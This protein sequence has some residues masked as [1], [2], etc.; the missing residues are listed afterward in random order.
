MSAPAR[1]NTRWRTR[2]ESRIVWVLLATALA[3]KVSA[4]Q[5]KIGEIDASLDTTL[6]TGIS[7][8]LSDPDRKY[9]GTASGGLQNSVNADD[10]NLNYMSGINSLIAKGTSDLELGFG[11]FK[12]FARAYYFYDFENENGDRARTPL[13]AEALER[14]GSDIRLL[15]AFVVGQFEIGTSPLDLRLGSQVLSWGEST[16]IQN[17]INVINP[18]DVSSI[19]V[20][21]AELK[22]ALLPVPMI[23]ASYG[24]TENVT[25]EGFYQFQWEETIIDPPGTYFSSNDFAGR[26]GSRVYL[27]FGAIADTSPLGFVSR[28]PDVDPSDSGQFGLAARI[29]VPE[30]NS[31]EFGFYFVNYHSR[32]PTIS[33]VTPSVPIN[34]NLTGPLTFVFTQAGLPPEQASAAASQLFGILAKYTVGGPGALTPQELAV[35]Q[36]PQSQAAIENAKRVAFLQSANTGQYLIEYG[37]DIQLYGASFNTTIGS[38]GISLQGEVSYKVGVPLQVDDVE[39]LFAALSAINPAFGPNNQLGNYLGQL[40]TYIP[41]YTKENVWQV[42]TTAT[43]VFGPA[44][45]ASQWLLLGEIGVTH[46]PGLPDKATLRFD[47]SGTFTSGSQ[48]FMD[49]TGNGMFPATPA[50]GFADQTSWGYQIVTRFDYTNVFWGLNM[51][52]LLAFAHDV[53]G[54]TPLPLGNFIEDRMT[55]TAALQFTYLNDWECEL[56]YTNYFGADTYNLLADRDFI[57]ATLKFSF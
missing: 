27:G 20:P 6:T 24:L 39:L 22:E 42:Q 34:P 47:G 46:V 44:L 33:A 25:L 21:G 8:R 48:E 49:N 7:S 32:L 19:R 40:D 30:L 36:A 4:F 9:Y 29:F 35:L 23:S 10:G 52:P 28:G 18:I 41:G 56:R 11:N 12:A 13:S 45:G 51:S 5:F 16:F 3:S 14:V 26:S 43:R 17:G 37:E 50:E 38:T 55:L 1:P 15:D 57:S 53:S 2:R 31:T 54:N